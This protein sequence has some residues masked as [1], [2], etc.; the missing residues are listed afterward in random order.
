MFKVK[1]AVTLLFILLAGIGK[2]TAQK[3]TVVKPNIC[4][5]GGTPSSAKI[6]EE[7]PDDLKAKYN[8]ISFSRPGFDDTPNES[9]DEK[10][11]FEL[12]KK[13]GLKKN[14]FA[15]VGISGGGPLAILIAEEFDLQHC[16]V[17]SGMVPAKQYFAYADS[18][19]TKSLMSSVLT[20]FSD[21]KKNVERFPNVAEV[22]K[23]ANSPLPK[24]IRACYDD[25]HFTLTN[26]S[27]N[28][29]VYNS[30]KVDWLHGEN[31][32]NV[33]LKSVQLFLSKFKKAELTIIPGASHAIDARVLVRQLVEKW[34]F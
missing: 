3:R 31:D 33:A 19:V 25:L 30:R 7:I 10:R 16:G 2:S 20:D 17:I 12:A 8:F 29:N 15:V 24:A 28:N 4:I 13:A 9:W 23:Q 14:D 5:L 26:V 27:F 32:K 11:L 21:F 18:T 1:I 6:I 22:L 34:Q